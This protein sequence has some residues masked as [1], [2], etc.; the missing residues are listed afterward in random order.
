ME[1]VKVENFSD[2]VLLGLVKEELNRDI[3]DIGR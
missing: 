3:I 2:E 1:E